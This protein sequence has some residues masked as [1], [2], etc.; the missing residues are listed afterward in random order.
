VPPRPVLQQ[1]TI[2]DRFAPPLPP[3]GDVAYLAP[4][5]GNADVTVAG[6]GPRARF[7]E[8]RPH[9]LTAGVAN[10]ET[11]LGDGM[12]ALAASG[13]LKPVLLGRAEGRE[14]PRSCSPARSADGRSSRRPSAARRRSA[15]RR[16]AADAGLHIN[17]LRWLSPTSGDAP[18]T[19][20]AGERL[21]AGF[22][23]A[24]PIARIA[25]PGG[26][27]ELGPAEEVARAAGVY[28]AI[29]TNGARDR[30]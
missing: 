2:F 27:R 8:Q 23:D 17:L 14:V 22:P 20:L 13:A 4:P 16:C 9:P 24:A 25:G 10:A 30:W 26:A 12:V 21:R 29:G 11:L 1:I 7:A 28:Q 19:R 15:Q 5:R 18:L 3:S 6:T